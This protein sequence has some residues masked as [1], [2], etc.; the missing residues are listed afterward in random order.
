MDE[1]ERIMMEG[2][3]DGGYVPEPQLITIKRHDNT[4]TVVEEVMF[5]DFKPGFIV[6]HFGDDTLKAYSNKGVGIVE[7]KKMP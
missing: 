4:V 5:V 3:L 2:I 7:A 6:C 1:S